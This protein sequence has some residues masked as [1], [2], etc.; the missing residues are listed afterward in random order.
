VAESLVAGV[1]LD[2]KLDVHIDALGQTLPGTVREIMPQADP[3][4]R[5]LLVKISL[6][7]QAGLVSGQFGTLSVPTGTYQAMII[8]AR[9]VRQVGQLQLVDVVDD[10]GV[11]HRRFVTLGRSHGDLVEVLSG[12][13]PAERVVVG[14]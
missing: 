6:P 9:A 1:K 13:K 14:S 8:P 11:P 12:L 5:T 7:L 3:R 4:T 2:Q 10:K